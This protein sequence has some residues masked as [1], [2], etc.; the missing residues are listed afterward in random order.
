MAN[1]LFAVV[2]KALHAAL[3]RRGIN[4][5]A[6]DP[7]FFPS[8]EEYTAVLRSASLVPAHVS[9]HPRPTPAPDLAAWVRLFAGHNFLS[10]MDVEEECAVVDEVVEAC[11]ETYRDEASG[12]W[13]MDYVRLRFVGVK[14]E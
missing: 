12:K 9:L 2:R 6:R 8:V 3:E 4:A 7:W 5:A 13:I 10:G 14:E 11:R 1:T